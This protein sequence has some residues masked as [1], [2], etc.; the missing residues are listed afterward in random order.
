MADVEDLKDA[1]F[2]EIVV[3]TSEQVV[4]NL[5]D[6]MPNLTQLKLNNSSLARCASCQSECGYQTFIANIKISMSVSQLSG[7]GD[8]AAEFAYSLAFA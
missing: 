1:N 5:G 2:L 3:D 6:L 7:F 8:F 4:E